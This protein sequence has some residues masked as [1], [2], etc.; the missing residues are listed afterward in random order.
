MKHKFLLIYTWFVRLCFIFF[1]DQPIIMRIRGFFYS[2]G[3]KKCGRNFQVS[4][5]VI[6]RNLEKISVGNNVYLAPNVIVNAVTD[7]FFSHEVMVGFN[8]VIVSGNHSFLDNSFR[9]GTSISSPIMI[10]SGSWIGA[11]CTVVAG[12]NVPSCSLVAANSCFTGQHTEEGIYGGV[13]SKFL[14]RILK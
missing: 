5:S 14:K 4:S 3:M 12:A 9:F 2:F 8:S 10:G 1:P 11:N 6:L 13:P 7:V